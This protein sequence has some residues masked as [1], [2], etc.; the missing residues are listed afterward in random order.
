MMGDAAG[1]VVLERADETTRGRRRS[2]TCSWGRWA[3]AVVPPAWQRPRGGIGASLHRPRRPR[4][5]SRLRRACG[6]AGPS[7]SCGAPPQRK[8]LGPGPLRRRS[9]AAPS[10]ERT[11]GGTVPA[12][13]GR[14]GRAGVHQRRPRGQHGF[15]GDLAGPVGTVRCALSTGRNCLRARCR[16]RPST[17]SPASPTPTARARR[18]RRSGSGV[19]HII[20]PMS[21]GG[22]VG[23]E[24]PVRAS[25]GR[26]PGWSQRRTG[27]PGRPPQPPIGRPPAGLPW[28]RAW[29]VGPLPIGE[30][31]GRG[32]SGRWCGLGWR[33]LPNP[34]IGRPRRSGRPPLESCRNSRS[35]SPPD[36]SPAVSNGASPVRAVERAA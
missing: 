26:R 25:S 18:G 16:R 19:R 21:A 20:L 7:C 28:R 36:S 6:R 34:G 12:T 29:R 8:S 9:R 32:H 31:A 35:S 5:R 15:G 2:P 1:A 23:H 4:L 11:A 27:R 3:Q 24:E 33:V 30:G 22:T 14:S 10:G 17:S 13:A